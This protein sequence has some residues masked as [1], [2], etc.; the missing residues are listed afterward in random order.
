MIN[1][2]PRALNSKNSVCSLSYQPTNAEYKGMEQLG[3]KCQ[4]CSFVALRTADCLHGGMEF[5]KISGKYYLL[6]FMCAQSQLLTRPVRI[7]IGELKYNHGQLVYCPE[8]TQG[9]IINNIRDIYVL[10]V[11]QRANKTSTLSEH[12]RGLRNDFYHKIINSLY[13]SF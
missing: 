4:C 10:S 8:L 2:T 3:F 9:Q 13:A 6:C 5:V 11:Y 7:D 1:F 12:I